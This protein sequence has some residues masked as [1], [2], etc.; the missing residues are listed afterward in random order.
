MPTSNPPSLDPARWS[1]IRVEIPTCSDPWLSDMHWR[2]ETCFFAAHSEDA[3]WDGWADRLRD[4]GILGFMRTPE[5][6]ERQCKARL[7][8]INGADPLAPSAQALATLAAQALS[9]SLARP[10]W[11]IGPVFAR[12][13]QTLASFE[14]EMGAHIE[15]HSIAR[16]VGLSGLPDLGSR[17]RL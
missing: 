15:R 1:A 14:E 4:L 11:L 10:D 9:A 8:E 13:G 3:D 7:R 6:L 5:R 17:G 2:F 16:E 12:P